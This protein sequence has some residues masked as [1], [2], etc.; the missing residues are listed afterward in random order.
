M[1][2]NRGETAETFRETLEFLKAAKPHQYIFSCLSIFPGT[3]DFSEAEKAGW[4][5]R[6]VYFTGDF[7]E[8]KTPFD[9]SEHDTRLMT[10]WFADNNGL[11][12]YYR[13]GV[14]EC[15]AILER[16]GDHHAAHM[17]LGG[18]LYRE[19]QL[20]DAEKHVLRALELGYP[21]PGLAHNYLACIAYQRGDL[22][23]MMDL[24]LRAAKLDPQHY[25]LIKNVEPRRYDDEDNEPILEP[26]DPDATTLERRST[27]KFGKRLRV[28]PP[29]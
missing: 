17:D 2:G 11:R 20:D 10:E 3:A 24:F 28:L 27:L 19:G 13:E 25:V 22:D 8:L 21:L 6:E 14:A 15:R 18:A 1:L 9:S 26:P 4:L 7:Q 5:D 29:E 23:R 16:L 12:D